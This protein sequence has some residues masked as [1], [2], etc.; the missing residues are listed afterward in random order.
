[1]AKNKNLQLSEIINQL[2]EERELYFNA[3]APPIIQTSNFCFSSVAEMRESLKHEDEN[4]FYTRGVNPTTDILRRKM[5]ALEH[6]EDCLVF[7]SGSAAI[8]AAIMVNVRNGDHVVCVTNPYT[9]TQKL[10]DQ[11][12]PRFG[13][14]TTYVDGRDPD[15]FLEA[16]QTNTKI[17]YLESP[18]SWTFDLQDIEV[19]TQIARKHGIITL[20]DNSYNSP[21]SSVPAGFGVDIILHSASKYISGHSDTVAG[22]LCAS[23]EM[24]TRIFESEFMTLGGIIS[25]FNAWLLLRGLRTLPIRLEQVSKTTARIVDFLER[26]PAV[27]KVFYPHSRNHPQYELARKQMKYG[28]GQFTMVLKEKDPVKIERFCDGFERLLL[29][30]SWGGHESLL[31][32]A[33]TLFESQNYSGGSLPVD[34]IRFYIGLEDAEY[35]LED[36]EQAFA[37]MH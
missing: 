25:P 31:F 20:I 5:A 9:W 15:N 27:E 28:A 14:R 2:G 36:F 11:L 6:T 30:C 24:T 33:L 3:V 17:F 1:M 4:P 7:A 35:L 18:N 12:L 8:G 26:H 16:L 37:C 22:I 21:V 19:I 13:V 29:A 32:P 34:M 10:L 23:K